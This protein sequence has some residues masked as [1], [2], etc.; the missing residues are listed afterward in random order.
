VRTTSDVGKQ[1]FVWLTRKVIDE[2]LRR[3]SSLVDEVTVDGGQSGFQRCGD[4]IEPD[5]GN[6]FWHRD[7][8]PPA[9]AQDSH[10]Q[11]VLGDEYCRDVTNG[12]G[13]PRRPS[14]TMA[15]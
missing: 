14:Q 10:T 4:V 9:G 8:A 13:M 7:V 2:H 6:V 5:D 12:R 15:L 1:K 11:L 3:C